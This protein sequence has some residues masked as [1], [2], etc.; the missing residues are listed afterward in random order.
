MCKK[1]RQSERETERK[2]DRD[3]DRDR[4][5]KNRPGK[6]LPNEIEIFSNNRYN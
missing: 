6:N 5:K 2:R 3:R 4:A 1:E